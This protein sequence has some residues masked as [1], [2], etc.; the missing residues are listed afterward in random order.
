METQ[1]MFEHFLKVTHSRFLLIAMTCC[2]PVSLPFV[3]G[4]AIGQTIDEVGISGA[5]V[6]EDRYPQRSYQFPNGVLSLADVVYSTLRGYR[7]LILDLYLP[8]G[9]GQDDAHHPLF[10][11]V[12][13]GGWQGGHTRHS[14]AFSDWPA[15]LASIA[16]E[17]F[18][19][20][21]VE[22]RLN[23]EAPFP[24]AFDDVRSAIRW[25]RTNATDYGIDKDTALIMGGSAGGQL[26]GLVGTAC[27]S[28]AYPESES[29]AA[30]ATESAC[31][32]GVV[33][34]YGVFDFGA[35]VPVGEATEGRGV[36]GPLGPY[37][38]CG[39]DFCDEEIVRA[40]SAISFVDAD[41]PPFLMIHGVDDPVV[42]VGQSRAMHA[43]LELAGVESTL[44]EIPGVRHSFIGDTPEATINA[45]QKAWDASIAF[46]KR[47]LIN[48]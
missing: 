45:S 38:D 27:G 23:G 14:G 36:G 28:N 44:I 18:V 20:A 35:I 9:A 24:A 46:L 6:L 30:T 25:L 17:G 13:G 34:W 33:T 40:A 48:D 22:Y 5:V 26:A 2:L 1:D 12:H 15:A 8:P 47:S 39:P 16:N 3:A 11:V 4:Q 7:P 31:V 21:S 37:L 32:Q 43:K 41:D 42:A 19:V 10:I 29:T